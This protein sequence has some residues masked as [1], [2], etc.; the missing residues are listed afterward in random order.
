[1]EYDE[2][3]YS[4]CGGKVILFTHLR[5]FLIKQPHLPCLKLSIG[6]LS[7]FD[8]FFFPILYYMQTYIFRGLFR[9]MSLLVAFVRRLARQHRM[10]VRD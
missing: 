5:L 2:V 3:R 6:R 1:M 7:I 8:L 4:L 10:I 9:S